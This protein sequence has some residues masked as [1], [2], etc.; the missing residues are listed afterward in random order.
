ME[1]A[2]QTLTRVH[3]WKIQYYGRDNERTVYSAAHLAYVQ[4]RLGLLREAISLR[5][6]T[7]DAARRTL[8]DAHW[9]SLECEVLLA[10]ALI[11]VGDLNEAREIKDRLLPVVSR[12][13]GPDHRLVGMLANLPV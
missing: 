5:R 10:E 9:R 13:L 12:V 1:Y 2:L 4:R 3:A 6:T 8:G 7:L 11:E